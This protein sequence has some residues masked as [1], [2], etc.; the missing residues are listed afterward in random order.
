MS[1]LDEL[2]KLYGLDTYN[3]RD[4]TKRISIL[5]NIIEDSKSW[6]E[7]ERRYHEVFVFWHGSVVLDDDLNQMKKIYR[8]NF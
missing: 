1:E 4:R 8:G 2:V 6:S 5:V 7:I 3:I